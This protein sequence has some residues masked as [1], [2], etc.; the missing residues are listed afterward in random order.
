MPTRHDPR[1]GSGH[2]RALGAERHHLEVAE[3]CGVAATSS[4]GPTWGYAELVPVVRLGHAVETGFSYNGESGYAPGERLTTE[5]LPPA[6]KDLIRR[7]A[8]RIALRW[9]ARGKTGPERHGTLVVRIT[10]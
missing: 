4:W 10:C 8:T 7:G 1:G 5:R 9:T 3:H 6:L 2:A